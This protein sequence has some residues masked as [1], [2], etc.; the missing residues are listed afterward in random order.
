MLFTLNLTHTHFGKNKTITTSLFVST[1]NSQDVYQWRLSPSLSKGTWSFSL[2]L[3]MWHFN[4]FRM[5]I[6]TFSLS[7]SNFQIRE[8]FTF[9]NH[10]HCVRK[11]FEWNNW[12]SSRIDSRLSGGG[13]DGQ[14]LPHQLPHE[15][16]RCALPPTPD[17]WS[18]WTSGICY[19]FHQSTI[20]FLVSFLPCHYRGPAVSSRK[21]RS[22]NVQMGCW[23]LFNQLFKIKSSS[24]A[25][26]KRTLKAGFE[27]CD[28]RQL[29]Q[30]Y[31]RISNWG[32]ILQFLDKSL[33]Q[34]T[35]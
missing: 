10:C 24:F 4:L 3:H 8:F 16:T 23:K 14:W 33:F 18:L 12:N 11:L 27:I 15:C 13:G 35:G 7:H 31:L 26:F 6:H 30:C 2:L 21:K 9:E 20:D 25:L 29:G 5:A 34:L 19:T 28:H 32:T 22:T 17:L 1:L